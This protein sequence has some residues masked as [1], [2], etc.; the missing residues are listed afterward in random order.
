MPL[1][2]AA[3]L[4]RAQLDKMLACEK[5]SRG[6]LGDFLRF[7]VEETLAGRESELKES[8][9]GVAVFQR[10]SDYDPRIDPIVRVEA[11]RLRAR[12]RQYYA[13][14]GIED[15]I[16][17]ELPKGGYAPMIK[18]RGA[19]GTSS[20]AGGW[21]WRWYAAGLAL[22]MSA[23]LLLWLLWPAPTSAPAATLLV[24][25]FTNL[26][27][28]SSSD[29]FSEGL[30]EELIDVLSHVDGLHVLTRGQAYRVRGVEAK[31]AARQVQADWVL[32]GS[33]RQAED[34]MRVAARLVDAVTGSIKWSQTYERR[35]ADVFALQQ[36]IAEAIAGALQLTLKISRGRP[37][38]RR[39][40]AN[41]EVYNLYLKGR[42]H[43]N[44]LNKEDAR[45]AVAYFEQAI[46]LD[47]NYAPAYAMLAN[48]YTMLGFYREVPQEVAWT[49][50][51]E[52]ARAA[53]KLDSGLAEAHAVMAVAR[54]FSAWRWHEAEQ[55]FR[56]ALELNP[57]S[58]QV[59]MMYAATCLIPLGRLAEAGEQLARAV[60]LDPLEPVSYY[61]RAYATLAEGRPAEA[62]AQYREFV[63]LNPTFVNAWWD[64]G[65]ALAY[66]QR[67]EEAR[68]AFLKAFHLRGEPDAQ[69]GAIELALLGQLDDARRIA[70]TYE[71]RGV[72]AIELARIYAVI[73]DQEDAFRWLEKAFEE[74]DGELVYVKTDPRLIKLRRN[75]R[76]E[77]I[78]RRM[79]LPK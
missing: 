48:I 61:M 47:T 67:Q 57:A 55:G 46:A 49:K 44:R 14:E 30:T 15:S 19:G 17:I 64:M 18:E 12:I 1:F 53:L 29:Y 38:S 24:S 39:Y 40:T 70:G 34:R 74:R 66:A 11:R 56:R 72:R 10:P 23:G 62:A 69:I 32:E 79:G 9:I 13:E 4:I 41:L 60:E 73:G 31:E 68:Q 59:R 8:V 28:E 2:P 21:H 33:V 43:W 63:E 71:S 54:I 36:E 3:D 35:R 22:A 42:Y 5:F 58:A 25:P 51:D 52:M 26:G 7:V 76:L 77:D 65:M 45:R 6:R 37:L 78:I 20:H 27:A 75:P 50:A 16:V